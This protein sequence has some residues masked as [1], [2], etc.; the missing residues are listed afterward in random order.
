[1]AHRWVESSS[2]DYPTT[3]YYAFKQAE[4]KKEGIASTG[5]ATFL[6]ALMNAGF[7]VVGTWPM[8]TE[9]PGRLIGKGT[10]ALASS[11]VLVCRQRPQTAETITRREF[12][13]ALESELPVSLKE[14]QHA[15][16]SPVDLPQSAIGPGMAIFSRYEKIIKSDGDAMTVTEALQLINHELS[17]L[18]D[19]QVSDMDANTRFASKW[20]AQHAFRAGSYGDAESIATATNVPVDEVHKSGILESAKGKVRIL[21]PAELPKNWSPQ[22]DATRTVWEIVHHLIRLGD[23]GSDTDCARVLAAIP[24]GEAAEARQLCY[25]LFTLCDQNGWSQEAQAYN[26]LIGNWQ[27]YAD[28]AG[29]LDR[30]DSKPVQGDFGL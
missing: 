23:T 7:A 10:N 2:R 15:N 24:S 21:R 29:S 28:L 17:H 16:L 5:W 19:G 4:I 20:V 18:L 1:V 9:S 6:G 3:I 13:E 27:D 22:T 30:E 12:I 11:I 25:R 26:Q 14:L 8:R